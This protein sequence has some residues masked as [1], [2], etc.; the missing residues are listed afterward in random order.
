V[1]VATMGLSRLE[2]SSRFGGINGGDHDSLISKK[3]VPNLQ[4]LVHHLLYILQDWSILDHPIRFYFSTSSFLIP[5]SGFRNKIL[6]KVARGVEESALS[7]RTQRV[8][9]GG[10]TAAA[11]NGQQQADKKQVKQHP[12][13][14]FIC[15]NF[16]FA[17]LIH[18]VCQD[19]I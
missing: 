12:S 11:P 15:F 14:R 18:P 6:K 5:Q 7:S 13:S 10:T 19:V 17:C 8:A 9:K 1:K 16:Y 3:F 2:I 4:R